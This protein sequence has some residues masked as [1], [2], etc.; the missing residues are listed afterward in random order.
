M[1]CIADLKFRDRGSMYNPIAPV[2]SGG[3][4]LGVLPETGASFNTMLLASV[5]FVLV[6]TGLVLIR[7]GRG[8]TPRFPS[9]E[10]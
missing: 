8:G 10:Q 5:A 6:L 2:V 1:G 4:A 7:I 3:G 9:V